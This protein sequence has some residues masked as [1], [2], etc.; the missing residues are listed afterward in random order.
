VRRPVLSCG[1]IA[2]AV[3]L[4]SVVLNSSTGPEA[5]T[6]MAVG[7]DG[8]IAE[9]PLKDAR[10]ALGYRHSI[11]EHPAVETFEVDDHGRFE[12]VHV[13]SPSEQVLDY[14]GVEGERTKHGGWRRL[15]FDEPPRF[16]RLPLIATPTGR[17]TLIV[18]QKRLALFEG[19]E[20]T[21]ITI[22][23]GPSQGCW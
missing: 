13:T 1:V 7:D 16:T 14:Y 21:H 10:F 18:D 3:L 11:Y 8:T 6:V 12:L 5:V 19:L 20:A 15:S 9:L 23:I 17:R 4:S 22:C 2:V